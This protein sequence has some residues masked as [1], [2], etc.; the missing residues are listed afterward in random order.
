MNENETKYFPRR[1]KSSHFIVDNNN[2]N[3]GDDDGIK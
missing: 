1:I 2:N 3:N